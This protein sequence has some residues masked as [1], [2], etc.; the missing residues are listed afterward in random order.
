[1]RYVND[2]FVISDSAK[3]NSL[4]FERLNSLQRAIK[5][6]KE[7]NQISFLDVLFKRNDN[8]FITSIFRKPSFT[9][10]Y[11]NFQ[12]YCSR[13]RKIGWI[14]TLFHRANKK[15]SPEVFQNELKVIK[16]LLIKNGYA[17]PLIDKV[18]KTESNRLKYIKPYGPEKCP[19]LL[20]LPYVGV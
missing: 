18:F 4:L 14:K 7:N 15:C 8:K 11:L 19:V 16:D 1:M 12:S 10:Q 17:K 13:R 3:V 9:G 5:L 20:I 6:T 2:C